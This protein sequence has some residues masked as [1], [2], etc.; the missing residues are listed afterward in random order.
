MFMLRQGVAGVEGDPLP[1]SSPRTGLPP[2]PPPSSSVCTPS[3]FFYCGEFVKGS[4]CHVFFSFKL[5]IQTLY[6]V[7]VLVDI[8]RTAL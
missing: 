8:L 7:H 4:L 1:W 5:M 6:C 3:R 2:P